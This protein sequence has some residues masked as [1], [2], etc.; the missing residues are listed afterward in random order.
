MEEAPQLDG[1]LTSMGTRDVAVAIRIP[2]KAS[3][4]LRLRQGQPWRGAVSENDQEVTLTITVDRTP[5]L[6]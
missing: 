3:R 2:V 5:D 6:Q 1:I 4:L